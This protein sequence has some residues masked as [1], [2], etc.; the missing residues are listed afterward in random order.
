[1]VLGSAIGVQVRAVL[2]AFLAAVTGQ[3]NTMNK[4]IPALLIIIGLLVI[5]YGL[6]KKDGGQAKRDLGKAEITL[7][8]RDSAVNGYFIAGGM[9]AAAGLV[10]LLVKKKG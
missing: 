7:G 6:M 10:L 2:G 1:M 9:V 8:Q 5:G 4:S 3:P